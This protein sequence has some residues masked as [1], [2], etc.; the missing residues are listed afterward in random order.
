MPGALAVL[1]QAERAADGVGDLSMVVPVADA[2]SEYF[3]WQGDADRAQGEARR[4]LALI[5]RG[6]RP[7]FPGRPARVAVV[8]GRWRTTNCRPGSPSRTG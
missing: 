3:L 2:R 8:A 6:R 7:T 1:D 5:E 4:A